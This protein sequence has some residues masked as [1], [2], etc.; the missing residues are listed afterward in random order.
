[1]SHIKLPE[2]IIEKT[3]HLDK[4]IIPGMIEKKKFVNKKT[5]I[6]LI[7]SEVVK[8]LF[9]FIDKLEERWQKFHI[10]MSY[11]LF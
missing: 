11:F 5:S 9:F 8:T 2:K 7:Y 6:I 4:K 1:V 10:L 3:Y